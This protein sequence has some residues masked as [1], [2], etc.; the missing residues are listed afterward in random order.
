MHVLRLIHRWI[1]ICLCLMFSAWFFSGAVLIYHPFPSLSQSERQAHRP[2]IDLSKITLS[3]SDA[4]HVSGIKN[5]TRLQLMDV[6]GKP[7]YIVHTDGGSAIAVPANDEKTAS[8]IDREVSGRLASAFFAHSI[9]IIEGPLDYDQWIVHQQFDAYRPFYR[10]HFQDPQATVLYVSSRTGEVLQRTQRPE[11]AWNYLGAIIHWIYPTILRRHWALW[12]QVVWWVSLLGVITTM[13]GFGLGV[14][15]LYSFR[16]VKRSGDWSS[17]SGWLRGHHIL[18]LFAGVLVLTW[19]ASG[20]LSMDHG[21]LFSTPMPDRS[22]LQDY[23]GMTLEDT[24]ALFTTTSL[25]TI[26]DVNEIEF[27]AVD[28]KPFALATGQNGVQLYE[29]VNAKELVLATLT[30]AKIVNAV[31][32][33]WT[34]SKV[35]LVQKLEKNDPYSQLR[36]SALPQNTLRLILDDPV[37][38]WV[39]IDM[40]SGMVLSVMDQSRRLYRWM[41]NGLHSLDIPGLVENRPLW[42]IVMLVLLSVGFTFSVTGVVIGWKRMCREWV[43]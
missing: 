8:L 27:L 30:K 15:Q 13:I 26:V 7:T 2:L 42:D 10:I 19:I 16:S 1:G 37:E 40:E 14:R 22:H 6:D 18:G 32:S 9:R 23:R 3:P 41:F 11:R 28:A 25:Q 4:L 39:H 12:D 24:I 20:W 33:A 31:Q 35:M 36:S 38:T 34:E 29:V 17:Y 21:R 43:S 5:P